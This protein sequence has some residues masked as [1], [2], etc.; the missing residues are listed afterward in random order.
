MLESDDYSSHVRAAGRISAGALLSPLP[1]LFAFGY[2]DYKDLIDKVNF[3]L[4]RVGC[5]GGYVYIYIYI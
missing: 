1:S 5:G 2:R 3:E 4:I